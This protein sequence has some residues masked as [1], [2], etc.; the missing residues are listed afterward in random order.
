MT[1]TNS[2]DEEVLDDYEVSDSEDDLS[3][4]TVESVD[5]SKSPRTKVKNKSRERSASKGG[6]RHGVFEQSVGWQLASSLVILYQ[7]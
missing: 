7:I 3:V 2:V 1:R 6:L 5:L 4:K